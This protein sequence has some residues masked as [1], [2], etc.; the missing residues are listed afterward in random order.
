[1]WF[2]QDNDLGPGVLKPGAG[3]RH[4]AIGRPFGRRLA[5]GRDDRGVGFGGPRSATRLASRDHELPTSPGRSARMTREFPGPL[6]TARPDSFTVA[7][8][9]TDTRRRGRLVGQENRHARRDHSPMGRSRK[10]RPYSTAFRWS[11]P[12]TL[13]LAV[14]CAQWRADVPDSLARPIKPAGLGGAE[15]PRQ[16]GAVGASGRATSDARVRL[17]GT[18]R[19]GEGRD[20]PQEGGPAVDL[21]PAIEGPRSAAAP[22]RPRPSEPSLP[23]DP[24][25]AANNSWPP[26]PSSWSCRRS[27]RPSS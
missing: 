4:H 16:E 22:N 7:T 10:V 1:M 3:D 24:D 13:I 17:A 23:F 5:E 8:L 21:P 19:P 12:V 15:A 6:D 26:S 11:W 18:S 9:Q 20:A 25:A 14:G 27:S 2:C